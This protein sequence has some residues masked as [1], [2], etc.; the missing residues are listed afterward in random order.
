MRTNKNESMYARIY[1]IVRMIPIGKVATYGQISRIAGRCSARNVGYAMSSVPFGSDVP[2][3]RVI[4]SRG[5]VSIRSGGDVCTAQRQMLE[6]EG[7]RFDEKG[8]INLDIFGWEGPAPLM[9][10]EAE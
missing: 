8:R 5:M 3:H 7:I 2:W 1:S 6:S 10:G 4:N 9:K